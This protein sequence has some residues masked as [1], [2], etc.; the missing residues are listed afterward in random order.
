M[1]TSVQATRRFG[2][3]PASRS[4]RW[5]VPKRLS[6]NLLAG[7]SVVV[8]AVVSFAAADTNGQTI[9]IWDGVFTDAQAAR[10]LVAYTGPC[11]KCHGYK[12]DGAP[13]DP[14]MISTRPVAGTKFLRDWD[15]RSLAALYEYTRAT[16]PENN[17]G[18]L[19]DQEFVDIIAYML[20]ASGLPSG[21]EELGSDLRRLEQLLIEPRR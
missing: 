4:C 3:E 5:P 10:G 2:L 16:M 19:S 1:R 15:G 12:L 18:F 9:S 17:P 8:A 6:C 21:D 7:K 14:D 13:D 11:D 20:L